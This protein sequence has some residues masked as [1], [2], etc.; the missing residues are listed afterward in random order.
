MSVRRRLQRTVRR[1]RNW[2]LHFNGA[3]IASW[4]PTF[5]LEVHQEDDPQWIGNSVAQLHREVRAHSRIHILYTCSGRT[6]KH[7]G[8]TCRSITGILQR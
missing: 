7:I 6:K 8:L 3:S 4:L 2:L 1:H 5:S